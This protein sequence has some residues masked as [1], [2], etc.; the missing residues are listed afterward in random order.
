MT[1]L[2]ERGPLPPRWL[3]GAA[4]RGGDDGRN[5]PDPFEGSVDTSVLDTKLLPQTDRAVCPAWPRYPAQR[6]AARGQ[7]IWIHNLG[8]WSSTCSPG[9]APPSPPGRSIFPIAAWLAASPIRSVTPTAPTG[10]FRSLRRFRRPAPARPSCPSSLPRAW[11]AS[12]ERLQ[13]SQ[14][15]R[16]DRAARLGSSLGRIR[17]DHSHRDHL[18]ALGHHRSDR[19]DRAADGTAAARTAI[20]LVSGTTPR[21]PRWR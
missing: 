3:G 6:A 14:E 7:H 11:T 2:H 17:R 16:F 5:R 18:S 8:V 4:R 9:S 15:R 10:S 12:R 1:S 13:R 19:Q 20:G 21:V